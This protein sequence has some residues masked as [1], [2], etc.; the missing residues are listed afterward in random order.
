MRAMTDEESPMEELSLPDQVNHWHSLAMQ[1]QS[2]RDT[3]SKKLDDAERQLTENRTHWIPNTNNPATAGNTRTLLP[4]NNS[5]P[6]QDC[7]RQLLQ[8]PA[9]G[10][11]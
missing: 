10:Q 9:L 6:L 1:L 2:E 5:K 3:L 8:A 7:V 11:H 4:I